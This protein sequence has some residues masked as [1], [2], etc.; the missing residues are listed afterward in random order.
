M[1]RLFAQWLHCID[2]KHEV[3]P[4]ALIPDRYRRPRPHI[5]SDEEIRRIVETAAELPSINGVRALTCSTLFGL[6]AVTGLRVSEAISLDVADV[7]LEA[8]LLTLRRGKLGKARLLPVSDCTRGRLVAYSKERDRLLG[9]PPEPFFVSD[10]GERITDCGARYNFAAVGRTIG[11]RPAEKFKRHG[12]G[13]RIHDLRHTFAVRTLV[14]WY[15]A[16]KNPAQEM[17]KL[18]TYLGHASP[19]HTY[20]YIEAVPELLDLASRRVEK[21]VRP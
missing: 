3:P 15:R 20:W 21:E 8:G 7:D 14:N 13:P 19:S 16:G 6:I 5:Y 17:I 4:Q 10:H 2:Q 9:A 12:R 1:V 11:L 18:T